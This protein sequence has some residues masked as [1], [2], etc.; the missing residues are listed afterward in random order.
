MNSSAPTLWRRSSRC[1][2]CSCVEVARI[3]GVVLVRDS[4]Q[5]GVPALA[6]T[7]QEW[8]DFVAGVMAGEF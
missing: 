3:D 1:A 6:F 5:P 7:E 2:D 8:M 4:K